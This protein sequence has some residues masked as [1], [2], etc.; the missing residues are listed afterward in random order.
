VFSIIASEIGYHDKAYAYFMQTARMDL[1]NSHS[2]TQYGVHTAAMAGAWMGVVYGF[3]G[4]RMEAGTLT[5]APHLP[6]QWSHYQ[7]KVLIR[8]QLLQV[9][10]DSSKTEYRLL[11][12]AALTL[13]HRARSLQLTPDAPVQT[14]QPTA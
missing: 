10:V 2:N 3:A 1:D 5:F 11:E 14:V 9:R 6:E 7:F 4:M 12:G 13:R 8:E